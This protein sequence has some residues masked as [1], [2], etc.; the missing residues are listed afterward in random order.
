MQRIEKKGITEKGEKKKKK[1]NNIFWMFVIIDI[2]MLVNGYVLTGIS[3]IYNLILFLFTSA[4][5]A[6]P[7]QTFHYLIELF[8]LSS[9]QS[10][11]VASKTTT[12][13]KEEIFMAWESSQ[14]NKKKEFTFLPKFLRNQKGSLK[15][16][17]FIRERIDFCVEIPFLFVLGL[18]FHRY[19]IEWNYCQ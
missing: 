13:T 17:V 2:I 15:I 19:A 18:F 14:K 12:T 5:A 9:K 7:P 8:H 1:L 4:A 16:V 10:F 3:G 11:C 6:P